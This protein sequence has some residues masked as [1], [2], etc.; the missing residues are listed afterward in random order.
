[1]ALLFELRVSEMGAA[2][3]WYL[4]DYQWQQ[5]QYI[6]GLHNFIYG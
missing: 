1:M 6:N 2:E 4:A 3:Q 5:Q